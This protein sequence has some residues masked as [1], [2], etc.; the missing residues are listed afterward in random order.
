MSN[1]RSELPPPSSRKI[2][3][4]RLPSGEKESLP[5]ATNVPR[6]LNGAPVACSDHLNRPIKGASTAKECDS[7][8]VR[9]PTRSCVEPRFIRKLFHHAAV[10]EDL[11][12]RSLKRKH[13]RL[14]VGGELRKNA[15]QHR[16]IMPLMSLRNRARAGRG[17]VQGASAAI[18]P[19]PMARLR[20]ETGV[21]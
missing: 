5:L 16:C 21:R 3:S 7:L 14:A 12:E 6:K 15:A 19:I 2:L 18:R 11:P 9:R 13:V 17:Q 8:S 1:Q 20:T 10:A 4:S